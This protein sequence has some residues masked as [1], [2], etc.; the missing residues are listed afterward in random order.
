MKLMKSLLI[1]SLMNPI[2]VTAG[3]EL[4]KDPQKILKPGEK[5][6]FQGVLVPYDIF[7][8][9]QVTEFETNILRHKSSD[10]EKELSELKTEPSIIQ[11]LWFIGGFILG[12]L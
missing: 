4:L 9:Y 12:L 6:P 3:D 8:E 10:C 7:R 5:A 2:S 1:L 11:P